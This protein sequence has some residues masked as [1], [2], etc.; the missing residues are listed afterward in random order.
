MPNFNSKNLPAEQNANSTRAEFHSRNE[1]VTL[2]QLCALVRRTP[3]SIRR[4]ERGAEPSFPKARYI[5]KRKYWL[6]S[7]IEHFLRNL[8]T[9]C[10]GKSA[11]SEVIRVLSGQS[12]VGGEGR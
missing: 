3:E 6:R 9:R 12:S 8:P 2:K 10:D 11:G 5:A 1:L 7:E 4:W